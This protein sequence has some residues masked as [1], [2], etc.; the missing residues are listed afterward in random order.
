MIKSVVCDLEIED[1]DDFISEIDNSPERQCI[2]YWYPV[3]PNPDFV[4][5]NPDFVDTDDS[6][7]GF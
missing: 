6:D 1:Y 2:G 4:D 5:P 7:D 3:Y